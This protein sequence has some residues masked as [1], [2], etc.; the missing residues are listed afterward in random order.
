MLYF[1]EQGGLA[2]EERLAIKEVTRLMLP[3][4]SNPV[5]SPCCVKRCT[6]CTQYMPTHTL[7][8]FPLLFIVATGLADGL[9]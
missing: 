2:E 7:Q 9:C 3:L 4:S 6:C 1:R 5:H 8:P